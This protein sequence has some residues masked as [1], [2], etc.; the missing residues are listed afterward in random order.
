MINTVTATSTVNALLASGIEPGST[1]YASQFSGMTFLVPAG[2]GYI[3]V[4]SQEAEGIY[5]MVK[6]GS[7]APVAISMQEMGDY[8]IPYQSNTQTF[9]YLWNGG[10]EGASGTRGKKSMADTRVRKVSYKGKSSGIQQVLYDVFGDQP[11]YDLS[12]QRIMQ[13]MKKGVYIHGNRKVVIK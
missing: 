12:G 13:P 11:W 10:T 4:T 1:E 9:V 7:N 3:I 8:S 2:D 6:I 5:L